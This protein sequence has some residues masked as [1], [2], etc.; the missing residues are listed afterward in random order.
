MR[1]IAG[2]LGG[3]LFNSPHT[4]STHPMSD[5]ARGG[6][7]NTL[8]DISRLTV[9][10][11]YAGTGAL[12]F[13]A[14]SRGASSAVAVELD[15]DAYKTIVANIQLLSL[16]DEVLAVRRQVGSW[17]SSHLDRYDIVM[18]DPPYTDLRRDILLKI[19]R[20][21]KP[22]GIFVLSWPGREPA[23]K[24]DGFCLRYQKSYGD[25]QLVYYQKTAKP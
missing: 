12:S 10:D 6:L 7:F 9:L 16:E 11:A 20:L 4:R 22:S 1:V 8:G 5:R 19:A 21:A 24:F 23:P 2:S 3:R 13:E 25:I 14:I 17:A 18:A 15:K